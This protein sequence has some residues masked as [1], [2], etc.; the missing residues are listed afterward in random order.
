MLI[1]HNG[2]G[3]A[4]TFSPS[5]PAITPP[6]LQLVKIPSALLPGARNAPDSSARDDPGDPFTPENR[7]FLAGNGLVEQAVQTAK[8]PVGERRSEKS[9]L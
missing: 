9:E 1:L 2:P 7:S 6:P 5:K 3:H 4:D 8:S